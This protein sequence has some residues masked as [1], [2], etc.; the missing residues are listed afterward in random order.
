[1]HYAISLQQYLLVSWLASNRYA[2]SYG[3]G[4]Q[5]SFVKY[6]T[7]QF[8]ARIREHIPQN[9]KHYLHENIWKIYNTINT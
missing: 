7:N 1:M 4:W 5:H 3:Y 2:I 9:L 6:I 8:I